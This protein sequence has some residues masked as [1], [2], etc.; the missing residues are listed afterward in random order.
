M[1]RV[2]FLS[3]FAKFPPEYLTNAVDQPEKPAGHAQ[4]LALKTF[5]YILLFFREPIPKQFYRRKF[6][7]RRN[8]CTVIRIEAWILSI[9]RHEFAPGKFTVENADTIKIDVKFA[10]MDGGAD[11]CGFSCHL[12]APCSFGKVPTRKKLYLAPFVSRPPSL[13]KSGKGF[14][15]IRLLA[16]WR[17]PLPSG[18][19]E[20][21]RLSC[22][23]P[24]T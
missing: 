23:H 3:E 11:V 8:T 12:T 1:D 2:W 19:L 17:G 5:L 15:C 22:F 24:Y 7:M 20:T 18:P 13:A 9:Y 16:S 21:V 4:A 6:C 14:C 10:F